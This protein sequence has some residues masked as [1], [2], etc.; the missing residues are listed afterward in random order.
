MWVHLRETLGRGA[1]DL[2]HDPGGTESSRPY[3]VEPPVDPLARPYMR[4]QTVPTPMR[5]PSVTGAVASSSSP[6]G[7]S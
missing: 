1:H 7:R 3:R 4:N 6:A 2:C 5:A